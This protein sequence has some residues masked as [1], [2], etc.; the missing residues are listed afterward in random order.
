MSRFFIDRPIFAWVLAIILML[1]GALALRSLAVAQFPSIA[2][3]TVQIV[4]SYPGANAE[5]L[6]NTTTKVIE[7][8]LK[9]IDNLRYFASSSDG[10]GNL[11]V[12][13]TFE[14]GTDPDI[15]QVQ[16]QNKL[17]QATPMLPQEVQQLGL[18]VTKSTSTFLMIVGIYADDGIHDQ[19]DAGDFIASSLQ[20][21]ISRI[22][23][24]GDTQLL[25]AQY[26]MRIWLDP[27]KMANLGITTTDVVNAI[28]AQNAQVSAGQIGGAPSPEG[29]ALNAAITAQSRLRTVD[30][31]REIMLR[32][33]S[34]G[35]VV[36][37][38]DVARISLGVENYGFSA[39]FNGHPA[40]GLGIK[41]APGANALDTVAAVKEEIGVLS[42]D[43]PVWVKYQ[44]PVD[45]S[46]FVALSVEQVVSTLIEAVVLVFLVM[47]LFLQNWR[48][49]LIPTIAIPVV[50]LGSIAI[51]AIAGFTI[52]TLTLFGMV[53]AI[54]LLV[55]DAIVV[56]ENV[57]RLIHTENLSPKE[58]A[59]QSMDEISGALVGIG[60]VLS[61][62][63]LPM[64]F[65]DG[66]TGVI[67]RQFSIT[68]ASSMA[69]SVLVALILTPALCATILKP[70][71]DD[72]AREAE[73]TTA[74]TRLLNRFF[75]K[76][77]A[78]F[79]RGVDRYGT[80]LGKIERRWGRTMSVYAVIVV[81]M[82]LIFMQLPG[83][84]L[85]DEDQGTIINQVSLPAGSTIA[86][87]NRALDRL[88][89]HYRKDEKDN[90]ANVF[91]L[92][93][94]GFA[95]QGQ[96]VGIAFVDM[97]PWSERPGAENTVAAVA[98][99]ANQ[100]FQK[101]S[102]GMV[103][104]FVPPAVQELGNASGF[105]VQLVD[106]GDL[107]HEKLTQIRNQFLGMAATDPRLVQVRPNGLEDTA[108]LKLDVDRAAAG[109]FGV[110]QSDINATISTAMGG[111]YVNDFIDR[112]RVKKVYVQA[113]EQFR[114]A[115]DS[116]GAFHVRGGNGAMAPISSFAT[117]EWTQ[118]PAKLERFNG[119][120]SMQIM[121]APAPGVSTG[122]AMKAV[123]EIAARL[124]AGV[125]IEWSGISYEEMTSGG[126]APAVY[127]L[128]MLIVFLCLAALYESW[129]VPVA[130]MLVVP[131]GV[132]GAV[133]A[134]TL[135]GL[136]NDIY[137][138]VGIITTIGVSAKNAILIVEFAE[139]K[140]REGLSPIQAALE[141]GKL[142]LRP[143]L[144]T[145]LAFTF[146]VLPLALSTGAGAGGQN[147]IGWAVV[148]GMVSATVLAVFFVPLF[149]TVVKRLFRRKYEE[150]IADLDGAGP[151]TP[152]EA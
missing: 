115:P 93:G 134:A 82:G 12:T 23:G 52:N 76:F 75:G 142:R 55:D 108:Q 54:G 5:T 88:R 92:A 41:L 57:E 112:D 1:A 20:D 104:A 146:G 140:M 21:P 118:G 66:S 141:A 89:D 3:P 46:T 8:Q 149:F 136:N 127:A 130:V 137:L 24:V 147:A 107:G 99:R 73:E 67:F 83:G 56:V 69:L 98:Q 109:A 90:V 60:L 10:A 31:F 120:S 96:N 87:T 65:F 51:L 40:A 114:S 84:F 113:D 129:S 103:I 150:H 29:Q 70:A 72:H 85:P 121:G 14:Q 2:P 86:E 16:V 36:Y 139:E 58:A 48:A 68:I 131:L 18:R 102:A 32:N 49:T 124:P 28:R 122:E 27:Y 42:K 148:G 34:D 151:A 50:L 125:D 133:I 78:A 39:K 33:N 45:N 38:S 17:A 111:S 64:A 13:L 128:S 9:G 144:M 79:D 43:F 77:N 26:A 105:D 80:M 44:F 132:F 22:S 15:A 37:L 152:Q 11:T 81:G 53:L 62:V 35:S 116:I 19:M 59:R 71:P 74:V 135:A 47:F 143:I 123:E 100:A 126:Q 61:A 6:E 63:F 119:Q 106:R 94:F 25:G 97:K 145:S 91:T 110:S 7:Q 30:E 101:I 138:Q 117:T 4:G 95:G